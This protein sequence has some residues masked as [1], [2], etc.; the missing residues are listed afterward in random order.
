MT[1]IIPRIHLNGT[2]KG[3][4]LDQLK[5][6]DRALGAAEEALGRAAPN[7]R[8]YYVIEPNPF[9]QARRRRLSLGLSVS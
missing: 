2:S 8:D 5:A 7:A 3:E 1:V 4:L 9:E 6:A